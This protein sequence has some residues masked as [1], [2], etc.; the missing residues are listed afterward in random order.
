MWRDKSSFFTCITTRSSTK[1]KTLIMGN[2]DVK[3]STNCGSVREDL[4]KSR[5]REVKIATFANTHIYGKFPQL[6]FIIEQLSGAAEA[7]RAH[8]P[9]DCGSKPH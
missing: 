9:E 6:F 5:S 7:R 2:H 4:G 8:N 3:E 1:K